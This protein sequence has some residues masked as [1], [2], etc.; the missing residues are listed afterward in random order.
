MRHPIGYAAR[1]PPRVFE[2]RIVR[3]PEPMRLI[4]PACIPLTS[5][6]SVA[7]PSTSP[8]RTRRTSG[9]SLPGIRSPSLQRHPPGAAAT[10]TSASSSTPAASSSS[11]S[12]SF[13]TRPAY[14][15]HSALRHMLHTEP[16]PG[17]PPSRKMLEH[18]S[19][20]PYSLAA[21]SA[22][23]T[24]SYYTVAA[25]PSDSDDES[26]VS[27]PRDIPPHPPI[28]LASQDSMFRLPTRWSD[29]VKQNMLSVSPDGRDVSFSGVAGSGDKDAAVRT[30]H[31]IPPACGIYY[32]E[33]EIT[34]RV[35]KGHEGD[36]VRVCV[37]FAGPEV[38][39]SRIPGLE[40][41][42]WGY[43]GDDGCV[44]SGEKTGSSF[45]QTFTVG[46]TIGCGIDFTTYRAFYTRN[47]TLLGTVFDNVG[48]NTP[49]YP[50]VGFRQSADSVRV[51]FGH[52][53]FRYDIDYHV[54]QQ[55]NA[56]W[57]KIL[58]TPL[59]ISVLE[60]KSIKQEP[61]SPPE[62]QTTRTDDQNKA[63]IS[64][65]VYS[66]LTH[67][68]Y[69]KTA[70]SFRNHQAK[71]GASSTTPGLPVP[72][73]TKLE[74]DSDVEMDAISRESNVASSTEDD[75][76][77]RTRIVR[78]VVNGDI[79]MAISETRKHYPQALAVED[80][81]MSFKLRCRKFVELILEAAVLKKKMKLKGVDPTME[82][83]IYGVPPAPRPER[84]EG[85]GGFTGIGEESM[86]M[87]IDE[88]IIV[89]ETLA[90]TNGTN[91]FASTPS[92]PI[93][94]RPASP[95]DS[96]FKDVTDTPFG[97]TPS[98]S[99]GPTS[100]PIVDSTRGTSPAPAVI[101]YENALNQAIIYG[102]GLSTDYKDDPRPEVKL[103]FKKT[104]G[105]V[106]WEDP[107]EAG[108]VAAEVASKEARIALGDELN[109]TILQSQGK[110]AVPALEWVYRCTAASI[111]ELGR[112]GV[113][114]A[115]FADMPREFLDAA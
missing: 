91:G 57:A 94:K 2:P 86:G 19:V 22:S 18:P 27:P 62:N 32:Y 61:Q 42:S 37:G 28:A 88:E 98:I 81:L 68:G 41:N 70:R 3:G 5:P 52:E 58:T 44:F 12:T 96:L 59:D 103:L 11:N 17:L 104:F 75:M 65:L 99:P 33:V 46:D 50:S 71:A 40:S 106:A 110:P 87:D 90:P 102:Q 79:D 9:A 97:S 74:G 115:A 84:T 39:L 25:S 100:A 112:Q 15:E 89:T 45:A 73:R 24:R 30:N 83:D 72:P 69:V 113:G 20:S 109:R 31:P 7:G 80:G 8:S 10:S 77:L 26:T 93:R 47:G 53:P 56:T 34:G 48:K 67:H 66:Y 105:I 101:D 23:Q 38:K 76:D 63:A 6:S 107:L 36:P 21:Q 49:L 14:L 95:V 85:R 1:P 64:Q 114:A 4:D 35:L 51:N 16:P 111:V 13:I 54:Q 60:S 55:R 43:Y 108:G 29:H 82:D 92:I 78:Y